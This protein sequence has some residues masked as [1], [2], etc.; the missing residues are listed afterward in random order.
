MEPPE[1]HGAGGQI[2]RRL[3]LW[4]ISVRGQ[5]PAVLYF[6]EWGPPGTWV[7]VPSDWSRNIVQGK[8]YDLAHGEGRRLWQACRAHSQ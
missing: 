7:P 6:F 3:F 2:C 1:R 4:G 8:T 5:F